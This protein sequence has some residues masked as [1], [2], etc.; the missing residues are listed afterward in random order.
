MVRRN[1]RG[2]QGQFSIFD[3]RFSIGDRGRFSI[4]DRG[5]F[6][7]GDRGRFSIGDRGRFSIGDRAGL[8][9]KSQ[10]SNLKFQIGFLVL[11]LVMMMA[12]SSAEQT[13]PSTS[14]PATGSS[15]VQGGGTFEGTIAMK[16]EAQ[17]GQQVGMTYHIKGQHSRIESTLSSLPGMQAVML[18]DISAGKMTTLIPQQKMYMTMDLG[19]MGEELKGIGEE[20][21]KPS[22]QEHQFPK[23]TPTG[24]QETIAGYPCEHWLMGDDQAIDMC[25]AKGLGYFGMGGGSGGIG[26]PRSLIFNPK[27][28]ALAAAHPEWVKLLDGGAF[29][30]KMTFSENGK[31]TMSMEATKIE[32]KALSDSLFTVPPGYKEFKSPLLGR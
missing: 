7:I 15:A 18:W 12:C 22:D 31:T 16:M 1:T 4:G 29:P 26:S 11:S 5:R 28:L 9:L 23:L 2:T 3:G 24:K 27:L 19:Q 6:S 25:V 20:A 32:P 14:T 8:P 13:A 10:I 17:G 30:L 21:E